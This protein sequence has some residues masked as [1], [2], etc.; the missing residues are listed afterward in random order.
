MLGR[1][2][3][4]CINAHI[5]ETI[6]PT[7]REL[8]GLPVTP[9]KLSESALVLIDCQNTYRQGVM[10]LVNVEPA[11]EHARQLLDRARTAGIPVFHVQHDAGAGSPYDVSAACGQIAEAVAPKSGESV[12]VKHFPDSF[13]G[14]RL[15]EELQAVGC[16]NLVLAGFMS[17]MCVNSTDRGYAVSIVEKATATRDLPDRNG[18]V[19][20]AADV[21][22]ASLCG[23]ADLVAV[24]VDDQ[25]QIPD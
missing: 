11:L 1:S 8:V 20:P 7:L 6:M 4:N 10:Q 21:Q 2:S 17:H 25:Q 13:A 3:D 12:I 19:I 23:L 18:G 24:I 5:K 9:A 15:A 14:T 16:K 22:R